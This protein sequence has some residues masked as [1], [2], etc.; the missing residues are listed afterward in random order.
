MIQ[1][2]QSD[3]RVNRLQDASLTDLYVQDKLL[4]RVTTVYLPSDEIMGL[5]KR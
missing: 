2:A 5:F 4:E 3:A 1:R